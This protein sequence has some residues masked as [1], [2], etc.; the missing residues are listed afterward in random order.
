MVE[1]SPALKKIQHETLKCLSKNGEKK[2]ESDVQSSPV[3]GEQISQISGTPVSWHFELEQVPRGGAYYYL[4]L[5][6]TLLKFFKI[7]EKSV[8]MPVLDPTV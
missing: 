6:T 3:E 2:L 7:D 5:T 4:N 1:C 8:R